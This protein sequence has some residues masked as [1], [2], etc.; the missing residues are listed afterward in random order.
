[1]IDHA[2]TLFDQGIITVPYSVKDK[3]T[4]FQ[5]G[6]WYKSPP[7]REAFIAGWL[8]YR[9]VKD[10][11]A[12][13]CGA[14]EVIEA[15]VKND[16]QQ[17]IQHRLNQCL[18]DNLSDETY[19]K[20]FIEQSPSG[21]M[22]FWYRVPIGEELGNQV[23]AHVE[24]TDDDRF[25]LGKP[26]NSSKIGTIVEVRGRGGMCTVAPSPGYTVI[27]GSLETLPIITSDER[28][29]ILMVGHSFNTY[30]APAET[31][32]YPAYQS[33]DTGTRPGDIYNQ[34]VG[35]EEFA[36]ML[37]EA[38]Y[39]RLRTF[40][41]NIYL[42]RPGA[43]NTAKHDAKIN[44]QKNVFVAYSTSIAEFEPEKGYTPFTV[45]TKLFCRG[46]YK[47]ATRQV[48][49]KGYEDPNRVRNAM[50]PAY[51]SAG[52][53]SEHVEDPFAIFDEE[54]DALAEF[55][56]FK[57]SLTRRPVLDFNLFIVSNGKLQPLAF[58]GALIAIY[59]QAKARK[60]TVLGLI[61][62][63]A[64]AGRQVMNVVY[65]ELGKIL[66]V[67]TEQGS[68]YFWETIWRIYV[69]ARVGE[70]SDRFHGYSLVDMDPK[71][72]L[73]AVDKMVK[74]L[75]PS[76]LILDGIIDFMFDMNNIEETS[77][78]IQV[79]RRWC[80]QGITVFPVLH[81]NPKDNKARGH[82]GTFLTN[83][84]D[85]AIQ[86]VPDEDD[87]THITVRNPWSRGPKF[88]AF[89]L[90]AGTDGILY[91]SGLPDYDY[92]LAK[93]DRIGAPA[94]NH[95]QEGDGDLDEETPEFEGVVTVLNAGDQISGWNKV[96]REE[97]TDDMLPF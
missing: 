27:Q 28:E 17:D 61:I 63:A 32:N 39:K 52:V 19:S 42:G 51:S 40:A 36:S 82:I 31:P 73:A 66:W 14:I 2:I 15:D 10:G 95:M 88:A 86:V 21:G 8:N 67:D 7:T 77:Q 29:L 33:T 20:L 55:E 76:V 58:P 6:E 46:D 80:A 38:G 96:S 25:A 91:Q 37:V 85:S 94:Q 50:V 53:P 89:D 93:P 47:E 78:I 62:A 87:P 59:G 54:L 92:T 4:Y 18:K 64:F 26:P 60:T 84:C 23:L 3:G 97:P 30:I 5:W 34:K 49:A 90:Y 16:P 56:Q 68:M 65:K 75:K 79:L 11:M 41:G 48:A 12:V 57:F 74:V 72:R 35:P 13:L 83:K 70:D 44:V 9:G 43:R 45:F 69:Q 81:L 24:Y 1:M 71:E 22:H